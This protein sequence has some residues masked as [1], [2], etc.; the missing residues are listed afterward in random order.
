MPDIPKVALL[1]ETARGYGRQMLRG[2]VRY[3]RLHGPWSFYLTPGDFE[4]VLPRMRQWGGR[5]VIAR[6]E[7]PGLAEAILE[8]NLPAIVLD[9]SEEQLRPDHPLAQLSE[10]CSDSVGAAKM[11]AEHLLLRGYRQFGF[12]G[13]PGKVWSDRREH[14][15]CEAIT[16]AGRQVTVYPAP[17]TKRDRVWERELP[18][19]AAWL[20]ELPKPA[21]LMVCNDDRGRQVLEACR[22]AAVRVPEELAV[23]GVDNDELLCELADPPLSSVAL[24]AEGAGYRAAEVLDRMMRSGRRGPPVRLV[25]EATHIVTRRSTDIIAIDDPDVAQ[26]LAFLHD[27]AAEPIRVEDVVRKLAVSR[28]KLEMRFRQIVGRTIHEELQRLRMERARRFLSQTDEPVG[29]IAERLGFSA[30][31]YFIQVFR[32]VHGMT[33]AQYRR[34]L[35]TTAADDEGE[36]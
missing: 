16:Q 2:I 27:H 1:I 26:A 36:P 17:T 22:E 21:G 33:P 6:V 7:T 14:A 19:L 30:P 15:F 32:A 28:R 29:R 5:G 9:L 24:N 23:I 25:A 4:Q 10:L 34:S 8:S 31:S 18:K 35:R 13:I 3:A 11:A 12:V 20:A